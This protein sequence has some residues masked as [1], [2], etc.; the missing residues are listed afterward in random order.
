M[1]ARF[2]RATQIRGGVLNVCHHQYCPDSRFPCADCRGS[3]AGRQ[4]CRTWRHRRRCIS[5]AA[6]TFLGKNKSKSAEGKLLTITKITAAVFVVI[7]ILATWLNARTYQILFY[8]EDGNEY[9]P[10][11]EA[12]VQYAQFAYQ[13][14]LTQEEPTATY[15]QLNESIKDVDEKRVALSYNAE[16]NAASYPTP[17]KEG[18]VGHWDPALPEKMGRKTI[19]TH[20]VYEIGK[21]NL[22]IN[23]QP[24]PSEDESV[25]DSAKAIYEH[26]YT[27]Q[28][29]IDAETIKAGLEIPEV[30]G[31]TV[32]WSA[33]IPETMPGNNVTI[34]VSYTANE[35]AEATPA[36]ATPAEATEP[37]VTTPAV[38]ATPADATPAEGET[39]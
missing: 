18:Y 23:L 8:D 2:I 22:T 20:V 1:P 3:D 29:A 31:Y 19:E 16:I 26:E 11:L 36:E 21:Y 14:G 35:V 6:D 17:A 37:E 4:R 24:I 9:F 7:A 38:E 27:Y 34:T 39:K 15:E 13:Y 32:T 12:Q 30:E 25:D 28:D 10:T 33:D 5:G